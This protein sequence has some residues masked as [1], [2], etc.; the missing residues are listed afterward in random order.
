MKQQKKRTHSEEFSTTD[1]LKNEKGF[2]F[3]S[4]FQF[5]IILFTT[6]IA[7]SIALYI[8]T[9]KKKSREMAKRRAADELL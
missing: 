3:H 8:G 9:V 5:K 2:L 7:L 6:L 1:P 4:T